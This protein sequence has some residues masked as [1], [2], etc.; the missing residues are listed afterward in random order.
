MIQVSSLGDPLLC[1]PPPS[2]L[3]V[4]TIARSKIKAKWSQ[5]NIKKKHLPSILKYRDYLL[6]KEWLKT[7]IQNDFSLLATYPTHAVCWDSPYKLNAAPYSEMHLPRA[8]RL[9]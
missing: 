3:S 7:Y 8:N 1:V 4:S 2:F 9:T 5:E 6:N